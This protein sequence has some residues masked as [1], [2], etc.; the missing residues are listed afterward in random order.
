VDDVTDGEDEEG[1]GEEEAEETHSEGVVYDL[2][3]REREV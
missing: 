1:D 3:E 2:R